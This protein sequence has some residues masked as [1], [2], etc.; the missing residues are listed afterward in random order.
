MEKK[1]VAEESANKFAIK[2]R[3]LA[4]SDKGIQE[5]YTSQFE[6]EK[7]HCE[8]LFFNYA[9]KNIYGFR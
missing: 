6:E 7:D 5:R 2:I 1:V 8:C 9:G 3:R 4:K